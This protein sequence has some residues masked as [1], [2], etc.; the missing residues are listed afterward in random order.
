[1][2][3]IARIF[4]LRVCGV[5]EVRPDFVG[6]LSAFPKEYQWLGPAEERHKAI[7]NAVPPALGF[8]LGVTVRMARRRGTDE[9]EDGEQ[10]EEMEVHRD[11]EADTYDMV[12]EVEEV[13]LAG[14]PDLPS[15]R[16]SRRSIVEEAVEEDDAVPER[17]KVRQP[18][19]SR[20]PSSSRGN[21]M[22][23]DDLVS[24][25]TEVR[26][27]RRSRRSLIEVVDAMEE[28]DSVQGEPDVRQIRRS[29]RSGGEL[30]GDVL[31][32]TPRGY[33]RGRRAPVVEIE[34][35]EEEE[36]VEV[37][38]TTRSRPSLMKG[39]ERSN[40]IIT[41]RSAMADEADQVVQPPRKAAK[42]RA[43]A[44]KPTEKPRSSPCQNGR[45]GKEVVIDLD[46]DGEN[47]NWMDNFV[48]DSNWGGNQ[49]R[50]TQN[51]NGV[52]KS[53]PGSGRVAKV[54]FFAFGRQEDLTNEDEEWV[55]D[56]SE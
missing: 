32:T 43:K 10:V 36:V 55:E 1:M 49:Q 14:E 5:V 12:D 24:A 13:D 16:R 56:G 41:I 8:A 6:C 17:P 51:S 22:E 28:D 44:A 19:K 46:S 30:L 40:S 11:V 7:G 20:K 48:V 31:E 26:Q 21:A 34:T 52:G 9:Q 42:G 25:E 2:T 53:S 47:T 29:R 18:G 33:G 27:T 23:E 54:Q 35:Q 50:S 39:K 45:K 3:F 15:P 4:L 38:R 37:S